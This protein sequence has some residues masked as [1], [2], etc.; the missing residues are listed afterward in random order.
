MPKKKTEKL[1]ETANTVSAEKET[2]Q[3]VEE[4]EAIANTFED[5]I[6]LD[7]LP[8]YHHELGIETD[9]NV[10][11]TN[12]QT[13]DEME[14][15]NWTD[16]RGFV[17]NKSLVWGILTSVQ[18]GLSENLPNGLYAIVTMPKYPDM[19]VAINEDDYWMENQVFGSAY[20][21]LSKEE[22]F[23]KRKRTMEY[24]IGARIPMFITEAKRIKLNSDFDTWQTP[25]KY[26]IKGDR[27]K[28]MKFYQKFWFYSQD[29]DK[30]INKNDTYTANVLQVRNNGVKVECCGVE[31]YIDAYELTGRTVVTDCTDCYINGSK[32][33]T[34]S[35]LSVKIKR[36]YIHHKGDPII[37]NGVPTGEKE[38]E[39]WVY[40]SVSGRLYDRGLTPKALSMVTIGSSIVGHVSGY[41]RQKHVYSINLTNGVLAS[42]HENK[43]L[44]CRR[45]DRNDRVL[46]TVEEKFDTYVRGRAK[47]W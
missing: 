36:C 18:K 35:K 22:Q 24:Q 43:L 4:S 27:K 14:T 46:V 19:Q 33:V 13:P 5:D 1:V 40:L 30:K 17:K 26:T 42:V 8:E 31:S 45:L 16:I 25:Y 20:G 7:K 38:K 15:K 6:K 23:E 39:D 41:N 44:G 29:T 10:M 3:T 28:A 37:K 21:K 32:V 12:F 2:V 9:P 34:G 47:R 11:N